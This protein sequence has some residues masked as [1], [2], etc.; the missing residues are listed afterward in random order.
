MI[1][2]LVLVAMAGCAT[3]FRAGWYAL[4]D[5]GDLALAVTNESSAPRSIETLRVNG[6]PVSVNKTWGPGEVKLF[7]LSDLSLGNCQLPFTLSADSAW[8]DRLIFVGVPSLPSI[9]PEKLHQCVSRLD[10]QPN[11]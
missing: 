5:D 11:R 7:R 6:N 2:S 9:W 8:Y 10:T 3:T 4:P 1:F